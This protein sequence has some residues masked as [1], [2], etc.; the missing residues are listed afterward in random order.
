MLLLVASVAG[1]DDRG[2]E[3]NTEKG[4]HN[5]SRCHGKLG[6]AVLPLPKIP[7]SRTDLSRSDICSL[8]AM[9]P[10][11]VPLGS[12]PAHSR[13]FADRNHA[14]DILVPRNGSLVEVG[15]LTGAFTRWMLR[16]LRP[17]SAVA[18]DV[19]GY[20]IKECASN[21]Q[22]TAAEVGAA[23]TCQHGD[24]KALLAKL[25]DDSQD[26]IYVDGDHNY[27]GVCGDLEAARPKVKIGGLMALNDYY[28][29]ETVFL[30]QRGRWGV[31][32]IIHATHE[33]LAR[34]ASDWEVA[35]ITMSPL[36]GGNQAI[37]A[38]AGSGK[39]KEP[40]QKGPALVRVAGGSF[41]PGLGPRSPRADN[42]VSRRL[43]QRDA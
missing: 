37:L 25:P 16:Q 35:Y 29:F 33:F 40:L 43:E 11:R 42:V 27:K 7:C 38:F 30:A 41:D 26:L 31:Y 18:M 8:L 14:L 39:Y 21:T 9:P 10:P 5:M 23:L 1:Q 32:G 28:L 15:T 17:I 3:E 12:V 24:S 36:A 34:Y 20:A 13:V 4:I 6:T 2:D 22:R 19:S